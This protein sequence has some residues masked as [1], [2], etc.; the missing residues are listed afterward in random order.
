MNPVAAPATL[1]P[2]VRLTGVMVKGLPPPA[3]A[4]SADRTISSQLVPAL[5]APLALALLIFTL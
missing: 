3:V 1:V 5:V 2:E 4:F